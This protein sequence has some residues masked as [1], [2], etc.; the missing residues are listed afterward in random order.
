MLSET[1]QNMY[2]TKCKKLYHSNTWK[3]T[4][5]M[6]YRREYSSLII[7]VFQIAQLFHYSPVMHQ[8]TGGFGKWWS[9]LPL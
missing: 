7:N 8:I 6:R 3:V 4:V 1:F 2:F 9:N 5:P